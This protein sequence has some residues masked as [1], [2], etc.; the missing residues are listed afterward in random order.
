MKTEVEEIPIN[1]IVLPGFS[2]REFIEK[3]SF[4]D[5]VSSLKKD[6][7][8]DDV[9]VTK[10][11]DKYILIDGGC[12]VRAAKEIGWKKIRALIIDVSDKEAYYLALKRNFLRKNLSELEEGKGF[13]KMIE[14]GYTIESLAKEFGRSEFTIRDRI[15]LLSLHESVQKEILK[16]KEERRLTATQA[17]KIA[18]IPVEYQPQ[19]AELSYGLSLEQTKDFVEKSKKELEETG[20]IQVTEAEVGFIKDLTAG[21]TKPVSEVTKPTGTILVNIVKL[22]VFKLALEINEKLREACEKIKE[23]PCP[24]KDVLEALEFDV[25]KVESL[26][27]SE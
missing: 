1:S 2:P 22:H 11:E 17:Q 14:L 21:P 23:V 20:K 25:K 4:D 16:P 10:R 6:S 8:W 15:K 19:V 26:G 12:R 5:L 24:K 27:T 18:E 13:A 9:W 7:Q 3:E